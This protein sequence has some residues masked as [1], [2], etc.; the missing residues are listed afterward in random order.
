[1]AEGTERRL[2]AI[3]SADVVG[4]SRLMGRDEA[5]TLQRLNAHRSELIDELIEKHGGRIVKTTGDGLLLEFPSVV[6]AVE[7]CLSFQTG[8]AKRNSDAG[9]EAIRFRIGAHLGDVIVEGDDIFGDGVNIAARLEAIAP[10]GGLALSDDAYRQVRDKVDIAWDDTGEQELKNIAR[11]IRVW[12]WS[13]QTET[14]FDITPQST[15]PALALPDKPSIAVLP[16]AN[17]SD[18]EEQEYFSDG[19][20]EDII[21]ALSKFRWFFVI[22][23]NSSFAY[24][25]RQVGTRQ[26]GHEL[27]VRYVLD[28]SVRRAGNRVRI[29]AQLEEA[30]TGKQIW[31][32]R[33][34]RPLVD[35]FEL[36]D[37]MTSAIS[38]ACGHELADAEQQRA[39]R[40]EPGHLGAWDLYLK[41]MWHLW[42]WA[43]HDLE[44]AETL[45]GKAIKTDPS[46]ACAHAGLAYLS[47]LLVQ[48]GVSDDPERDI[49]QGLVAAETA[50]QLDEKDAFAHFSL[51]RIHMM[52]VDGKSAMGEI[53]RA[54][55]LN[56]NLAPASYAMGYLL[57][58]LERENEAI[59]YL[60]RALRL[61]P[62]DQLGWAVEF[63]KALALQSLG[64]LDETEK[65]FE[66]I[67]RYPAN[68]HWPFTGKAALMAELGQMEEAEKALKI[69][70]ERRPELSVTFVD[71]TLPQ[72]D[73][74]IK[75]KLRENLRIAGLEE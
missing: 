55:E 4:Y 73:C 72:F 41:G 22:A 37:E 24:K 23:R 46:L 42:R 49:A 66:K 60:D 16:F 44:V 61:S 54:L 75:R 47:Y 57:S 31:A 9:D 53:E 29:S 19:V 36:Q 10:P 8:M 39:T 70:L 51:G 74:T 32:E 18:D 69:A 38:G 30:A 15:E 40:T 20:A 2:A 17:L 50:I 5:G 1:M 35:I 52:R 12:R 6:A 11:P 64:H 21:T 26:I 58:M 48:S 45:L 33:Y 67:C 13:P 59:S 34:D 3:V 7:C 28:G 63:I 62:S 65:L 68:Q 14:A 43:D 71:K 25:G 27:G 56:P